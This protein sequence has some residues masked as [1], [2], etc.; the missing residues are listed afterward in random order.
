VLLNIQYHQ[1]IKRGS[2]TSN[3]SARDRE[4]HTYSWLENKLN[5]VGKIPP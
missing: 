4:F 1:H 3:A 5:L 2:N